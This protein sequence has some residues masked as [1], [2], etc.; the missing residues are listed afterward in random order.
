MNFCKE[1]KFKL[2]KL[3]ATPGAI[4]AMAESGRSPEALLRRHQS[5]DWADICSEDKSLNDAAIGCEGDFDNQ[6]R[7]L[8]V[9]EIGKE[10]LWVITEWDRSA[11]TILL[12]GE[13]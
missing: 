13:Y 11:T 6:Q 4:S 7:V 3:V 8:S 2:G 10:K 12:P 1:P 5:G 9:Y